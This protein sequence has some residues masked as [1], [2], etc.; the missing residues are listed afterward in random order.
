M[1]AVTLPYYVTIINDLNLI[2]E[3]REKRR[4]TV[5]ED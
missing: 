2:K 3:K 5:D 4:S 1:N